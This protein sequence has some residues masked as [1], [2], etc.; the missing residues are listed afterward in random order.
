MSADLLRRAAALMR[1]RAEAATFVDSTG[2]AVPWYMDPNDFDEGDAEHINSWSPAVAIAVADWLDVTADMYPCQCGLM[3]DDPLCEHEQA[4]AV[5]RL[6][7]G[8]PT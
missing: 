3:G 7:L 5:A 2:G 4:L 1:E 8:E 6:Y